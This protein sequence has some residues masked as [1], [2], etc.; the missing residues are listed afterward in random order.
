MYPAGADPG[1][2]FSTM[3]TDRAFACPQL[4]SG[5]YGYEFADPDAPT[6]SMY[7]GPRPPGASHA[8]ELAHLFDLRGGAP[9]R[10]VVHTGLMPAQRELGD[11]TIDLWTGFARTGRVPLSPRPAVQS[12][13]PQRIGPVDGWTEHHCAFL[14]RQRLTAWAVAGRMALDRPARQAWW[15]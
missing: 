9:Y 10:G 6:Y 3:D 12:L 4:R 1:L 15:A 14:D 8:S 11:A 13:A 7:F 2:A 5:T